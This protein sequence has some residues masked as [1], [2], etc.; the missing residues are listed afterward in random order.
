MENIFEP[1]IEKLSEN[2]LKK[3]KEDL[4]GKT[5]GILFEKH[6]TKRFSER[7]NSTFQKY[8]F[9]TLNN[10]NSINFT[11]FKS[12][13]SLQGVDNK[14]LNDTLNAN[15][16]DIIRL[17][18]SN[19][20]S[21]LYFKYFE[22]QSIKYNEGIREKNL[23]SFYTKLVHTFKPDEF[24]PVDMPMR[25]H[26]KLQNESYFVSMIA[27]SKAFNIWAV[28]NKDCVDK[29]KILFTDYLTN[30]FNLKPESL[31]ITDIKI[32][33]TIFWSIANPTK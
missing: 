19:K 11:E 16:L 15:K 7:K 1:Y 32:L 28:D 24:T 12:Q 21:E 33:N 26:F 13:Y 30:K 27:I 10:I 17:I 6:F 20:L 2:V 25:K 14:Y 9:K 29:I 5:D 4:E 3:I 31:I 18:N 8:Y 22:S 23:G